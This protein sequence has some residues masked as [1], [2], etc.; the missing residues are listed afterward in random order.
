MTTHGPVDDAPVD[1]DPADSDAVD[2]EKRIHRLTRRLER[3][4]SARE[5][6]EKIAEDGMRRLFLANQELDA[7]VEER[8]AELEAERRDA[9]RSAGERAEFLRLLSRETRSPLNGVIGVMEVLGEKAETEQ[10]R[11]W[12][13]DGLESARTL[14]SIMT[15][16]LLF[17]E[18]EENLPI[19]TTTVDPADV[20]SAVGARWK[21]DALRAGLLLSTENRC[22]TDVMVQTNINDVHL[23]LDELVS[24]AVK[25]G[26]PGLLRVVSD[27]ERSYSGNVDSVDFIVEDSGPGMA[28][29][30]TL[31]DGSFQDRQ[32]T[33]ARGMGY[34]LITRLAER[35]G[36]VV[37][38]TSEPGRGTVVRLRLPARVEAPP[39]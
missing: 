24:N 4:R 32:N 15:R 6:A 19:E 37:M 12:L 1:S 34:S 26:D 35:A 30:E 25:H 11:A 2:A 29:T 22:P 13:T 33:G 23:I 18:L 20:V 17:L 16:L 28:N 14:D 7:R 5:Q 8:T 27:V 31:L 10:M 3:E 9:A 39:E 36:A 38:I 21:H